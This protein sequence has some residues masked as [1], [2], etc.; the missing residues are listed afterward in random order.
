MSVVLETGAEMEESD[1][2]W[3]TEEPRF[4]N[5]Q[6]QH[7]ECHPVEPRGSTEALKAVIQANWGVE[8]H[9]KQTTWWYNPRLQCNLW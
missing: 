6:E 8:D 5:A 1:G 4:S 2:D 9:E 3:A 7:S